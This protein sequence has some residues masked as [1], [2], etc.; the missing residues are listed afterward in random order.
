MKTAHLPGHCA[1]R[2]PKSNSGFRDVKP[3]FGEHAFVLELPAGNFWTTD[4]RLHQRM[5]VENVHG[6]TLVYRKDLWVQG[7]RSPEVNL[8]EDAW[9]LHRAMRS[10]K[11]L[12]RL[13]NPGVFVYVRHGTNAWREFTPGS[14]IDPNG[15]KRIPRPLNFPDPA[16]S[17]FLTASAN[18]C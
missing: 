10:G 17:F 16:L 2:R 5:F 4:A 18:H 7:L 14:F 11:R 15:W 12:L 3:F 8:A 13:A 9:L 6:G 1:E